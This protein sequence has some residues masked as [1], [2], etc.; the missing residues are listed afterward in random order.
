LSVNAKEHSTMSD[1]ALLSDAELDAVSGGGG[2][3][4]LAGGAGG[5]GGTALVGGQIQAKG[6]VI[7]SNVNLGVRNSIAYAGG[8]AGGSIVILG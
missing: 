1:L 8:G 2:L 7:L 6:L 3:L 4:V 5:S